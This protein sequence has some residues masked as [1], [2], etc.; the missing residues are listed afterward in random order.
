MINSNVV[1]CSTPMG[2]VYCEGPN[3]CSQIPREVWG[4]KRLNV[5]NNN[6]TYCHRIAKEGIK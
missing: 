6:N 5:K 1:N 2:L 4:K 3:V